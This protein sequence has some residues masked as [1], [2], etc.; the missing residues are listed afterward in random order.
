VT[1]T[2]LLARFSS[3]LRDGNGTG[4][5]DLFSEDATYDEP[6]RFAFRGRA[7]IREFFADFT[8]NHRNARFTVSR[9]VTQGD[10][11]AAEWRWDYVRNADGTQRAFGGIAM[12][13]VRNESIQSWRGYSAL[14]ANEP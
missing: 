11:L 7:S 4:A 13:Q 9:L 10:L 8:A 3:L 14:I 1:G 2:E 5:A 12:I 6:P